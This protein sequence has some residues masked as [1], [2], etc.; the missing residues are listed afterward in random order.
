[1]GSCWTIRGGKLEDTCFR[2]TLCACFEY[3]WTVRMCFLLCFCCCFFLSLSASDDDVT[4]WIYPSHLTGYITP[5][6][7]VV[8]SFH[9]SLSLSSSS[10]VS[11]WCRFRP[12]DDR[13][14]TPQAT[15]RRGPVTF[16]FRIP[17]SPRL[18]SD[19]VDDVDATYDT[20]RCTMQNTTFR[21]LYG[22]GKTLGDTGC[23]R[24][25]SDSDEKY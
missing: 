7:F 19:T 12:R 22:L 18:L 21:T 9:F 2:A 24:G 17:W 1:M 14:S 6:S 23:W 3:D 11:V 25:S 8:F 5:I 20:C 10:R 16:F 13:T 4:A 15:A